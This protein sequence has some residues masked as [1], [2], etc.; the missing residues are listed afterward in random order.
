MPGLPE[1][2]LVRRIEETIPK[3]QRLI[4][5]KNSK[6]TS[7]SAAV[8]VKRSGGEPIAMGPIRSI[9]M[10]M[11]VSR[12]QKPGKE[13]TPKPTAATDREQSS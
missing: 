7:G 4:V 5:V 3:S 1:A 13:A 9:A 12:S 6:S 2:E 11:G 10:S 8:I